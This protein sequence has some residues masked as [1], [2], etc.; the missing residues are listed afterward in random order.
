MILRNSS[1]CL[2]SPRLAPKIEN[3]VL[4]VCV[5]TFEAIPIRG[6]ALRMQ[7]KLQ[8]F[9]VKLFPRFGAKSTFSS[10]VTTSIRFCLPSEV[11]ETIS[12]AMNKI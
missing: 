12:R 4:C 9:K 7:F 3:R 8:M 11:P 1:G 2:V 10:Y 5:R 6:I